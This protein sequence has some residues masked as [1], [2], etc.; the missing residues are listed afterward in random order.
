MKCSAMQSSRSVAVIGAAGAC[1]RQL[2]TQLLHQ[3]TIHPDARLQMVGHRGGSSEHEL[4]GLRADLRDAFADDAPEIEL[5]LDAEGVDAEVV[6]MLAGATVARNLSVPPDRA[7][8]AAVNRSMFEEFADALASRPG[9]AP[10][11]IVQSNPV[12]LGVEV[13]GERLGRGRVVGAGA[14]SDTLRFRREIADSLGVRRGAVSAMV[15][16]QHGDNMVPLWSSIA[17]DGIDDSSLQTWIEHQRSGR[18]PDAFVAE[19]TEHKIRLLQM[20]IDGRTDE[21]FAECALLPADLRAAIKPFLVLFT[22][23]HSTEIVTAHAV[24]DLVEIVLGGEER[25]VPLQVHL[26]GEMFDLHGVG[27]VPVVFGSEG[28]SEVVAPECS[29]G[30]REALTAAFAAIGRL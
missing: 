5:V 10:I 14:W 3:K 13:F 4:H 1:G 27:A 8:L 30:E 7:R 19:V 17:V 25:V 20:V 29:V 15:L 12:E 21:A 18:D 28:W 24:A 9:D 11:V 26:A 23:G 2:V 22:S 6:V 16:G